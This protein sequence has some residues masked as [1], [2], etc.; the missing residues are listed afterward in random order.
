MRPPVMRR[1][2]LKTSPAPRSTEWVV[3]IGECGG[4]Q[5]AADAG[6]VELPLS[7]VA[8]GDGRG[9]RGRGRARELAGS[10]ALI[11]VARVLVQERRAAR[12]RR[13]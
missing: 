4:T 9:W 6:V 3:E 8:L 12:R 2:S 11:E 7:V 10:G 5:I 13:G 1:A